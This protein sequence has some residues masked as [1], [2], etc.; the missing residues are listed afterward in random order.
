MD[1]FT[2]DRM[3]EEDSCCI[4]DGYDDPIMEVLEFL[5]SERDR[6]I[7]LNDQENKAVALMHWFGC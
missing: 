1:N 5:Q 3:E 4:F 6:K 7:S 2:Y